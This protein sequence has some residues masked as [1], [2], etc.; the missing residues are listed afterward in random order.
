MLSQVDLSDNWLE[1]EGGRA[2]AEGIRVSRSLTQV[3]SNLIP[4]LISLAQPHGAP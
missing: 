3:Q 4:H 1:P 2:I